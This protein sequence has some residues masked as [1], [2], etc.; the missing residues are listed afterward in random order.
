[1]PSDDPLQALTELRREIADLKQQMP[2]A[3]A[4]APDRGADRNPRTDAPREP[5]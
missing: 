3:Q 2:L 5:D 4:P 1:V